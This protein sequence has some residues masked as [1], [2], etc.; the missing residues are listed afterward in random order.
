MGYSIYTIVFYGNVV[1]DQYTGQL[2][3]NAE[4]QQIIETFLKGYFKGM[5]GKGVI[6]INFST[7]TQGFTDVGN[8]GISPTLDKGV[9]GRAAVLR[10]P[11]TDAQV[12]SDI[13]IS[14]PELHSAATQE[15]LTLLEYFRLIFAD[16]RLHALAS[17]FSS[18]A[19]PQD[20]PLT[21]GPSSA[22]G[23]I[24]AFDQDG[25]VLL[26]NVPIDTQTAFA[27]MLI[28]AMNKINGTT[29]K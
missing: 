3:Q 19:I 28:N 10:D 13:L 7:N 1:S 21:E 15:G 23:Y 4:N 16:E 27:Q 20:T 22:A 29:D 6:H 8:F 17:N 2:T 11:M 14:I 18:E 25:A 9:V 5:K 12:R 24:A 26:N